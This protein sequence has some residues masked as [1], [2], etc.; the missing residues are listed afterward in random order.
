MN[1]IKF[2]SG[3]SQASTGGNT[4]KKLLIILVAFLIAGLFAGLAMARDCKTLVQGQ[5]GITIG[6]EN[7]VLENFILMNGPGWRGTADLKSIFG[8]DLADGL[9]VVCNDNGIEIAGL[10][11]IET[12]SGLQCLLEPIDGMQCVAFGTKM[13]CFDHAVGWVDLLRPL[14]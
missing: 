7:F 9:D 2:Q 6:G 4:M 3:E 8:Q 10:P 13:Y 1:V 11:C 12:D 14:E 5:Y